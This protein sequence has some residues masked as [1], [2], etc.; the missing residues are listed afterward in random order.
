MY[1]KAR[2]HL[3]AG[4][5]ILITVSP[6]VP[7]IA[8]SVNASAGRHDS[9]C[10]D[11]VVFTT[12]GHGGATTSRSCPGRVNTPTDVT[13]PSHTTIDIRNINP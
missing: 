9:E 13:E 4:L 8:W 3:A 2:R 1:T 11:T 12:T 6:I 7:V 10:V 5:T